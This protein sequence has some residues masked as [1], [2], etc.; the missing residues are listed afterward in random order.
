MAKRPRRRQSTRN[1]ID[2]VRALLLLRS[3][4]WSMGDKHGLTP[5][6]MQMLVYLT[7]ANEF[8]RTPAALAD[9]SGTTRGTVSQ[10][11]KIL[12]RK[13]LVDRS[14]DPYDGRS[15]R[16]NL[17][18]AGRRVIKGPGGFDQFVVGLERRMSRS[19]RRAFE[20]GIRAVV[21][22]LV[23]RGEHAS[24]GSCTTCAHFKPNGAAAGR[25]ELFDV[26]RGPRR[27]EQ[28]CQYVEPHS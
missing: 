2:L 24:F 17:T 23:D 8:S 10:T 27:L 26:S 5:A 21:G 18:P 3:Q 9:F 4:S 28:Y 19:D 1:S 25:C 7:Y 6:Q 14:S 13:G 11:L 16:I 15:L 12:Q 22:A 20:E